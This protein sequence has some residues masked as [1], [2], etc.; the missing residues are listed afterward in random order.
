MLE[1]LAGKITPM[2]RFLNFVQQIENSSKVLPKLLLQTIRNDARSTTGSNLRNILLLIR[3]YDFIQYE[4]ILDDNKCKIDMI[5]KLI[6][7]KWGEAGIEN[8]STAEINEL[9]EHICT[10]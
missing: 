2:K 9:L 6:D 4:P 8:L 10:S 3:K 7:V 5:I 1:P